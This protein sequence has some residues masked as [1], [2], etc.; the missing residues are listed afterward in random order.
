MDQ[1][2]VHR[3]EELLT[4]CR[5]ARTGG[6][7]GGRAWIA[8]FLEDDSHTSIRLVEFVERGSDLP[9]ISGIVVQEGNDRDIAIGAGIR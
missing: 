2:P 5:D 3:E 4:C 9:A 6:K 8:E 7:L 1:I